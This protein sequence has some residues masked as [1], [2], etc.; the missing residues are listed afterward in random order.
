M[1][2]THQETK[3]Q[4]Y[5]FD[6]IGAARCNSHVLVGRGKPSAAAGPAIFCVGLEVDGELGQAD[7]EHR[8][9]YGLG[10]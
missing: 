1:V 3:T 9:Q 4:S 2:E 6:A 5:H 10:R 7:N 8:G